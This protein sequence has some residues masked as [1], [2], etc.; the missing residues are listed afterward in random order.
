MKKKCSLLS[1]Q[2]DHY[3]TPSWEHQGSACEFLCYLL[4]IKTI[5]YEVASK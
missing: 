5:A 4:K 3:Y 1:E 2:S